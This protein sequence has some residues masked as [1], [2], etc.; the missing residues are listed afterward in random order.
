[1]QKN[2]IFVRCQIL[3]EFFFVWKLK[4]KLILFLLVRQ[5]YV[6]KQIKAE[7]LNKNM[8]FRLEHYRGLGF[9]AES[10]VKRWLLLFYSSISNQFNALR[11]EKFIV[12]TKHQDSDINLLHL[13]LKNGGKNLLKKFVHFNFNFFANFYDVLHQAYT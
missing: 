3:S 11:A 6:S 1:M 4:R 2:V 13:P 9:K 10:T 7:K 12:T 5:F 8:T